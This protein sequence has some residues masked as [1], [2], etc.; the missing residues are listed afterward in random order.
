MSKEAV[1]QRVTMAAEGGTQSLLPYLKTLLPSN[2]GYLA[3]LYLKV[4]RDRSAA[5]GL[6]R[7]KNKSVK[8]GQIALYGVKRLIWRDKELALKA[9][10]K[11]RANIYLQRCS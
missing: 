8:E 2:E 6:Y 4:R 10:G 11:A 7:Y 5:A 9:W 1:W 3:D